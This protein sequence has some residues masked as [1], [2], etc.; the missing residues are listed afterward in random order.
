MIAIIVFR[1]LSQHYKQNDAQREDVGLEAIIGCALGPCVHL[2]CHVFIS[3]HLTDT[4]LRFIL[5]QSQQLGKVMR[6][7]DFTC[8]A[9]CDRT[10]HAVE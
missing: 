9:V 8:G 5:A 10:K 7:C 1:T 3:A 2:R 6:D 4:I